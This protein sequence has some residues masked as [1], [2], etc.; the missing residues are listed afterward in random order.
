MSET[1]V[2]EKIEKTYFVFCNFFLKILPFTTCSGKIWYSQT[3]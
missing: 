3:W 1:R 2:V